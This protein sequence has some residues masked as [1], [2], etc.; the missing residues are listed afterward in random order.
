MMTNLKLLAAVFWAAVLRR[1]CRLG[2]ASAS[3]HA[4]YSVGTHLL[5]NAVTNEANNDRFYNTSSGF[6]GGSVAS[7]AL[8]LHSNEQLRVAN[9]R[10]I[11]KY[12]TLHVRVG[13]LYRG[14]F[15]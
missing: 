10:S 2:V 3:R 5:G 6:L 11:L 15:I 14:G 7:Q 1:K 12:G 13:S 9:R 8:Y 4:G